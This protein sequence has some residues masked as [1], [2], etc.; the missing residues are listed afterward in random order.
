MHPHPDDMTNAIDKAATNGY[1][2]GVKAA[3][4]ATTNGATSNGTTTKETPTNG[5]TTK[6]TPQNGTT[7]A[8]LPPATSP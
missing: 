2:N 5:T 3:P 7:T 6:E 1:T 4:P 8:P